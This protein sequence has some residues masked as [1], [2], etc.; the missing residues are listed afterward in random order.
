MSASAAAFFESGRQGTQLI[1]PAARVGLS[2]AGFFCPWCRNQELCTSRAFDVGG[3][4]VPQL[5]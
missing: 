5:Q 2:G 3:K 1:S 4:K